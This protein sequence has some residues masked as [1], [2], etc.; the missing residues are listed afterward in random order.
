MNL[1]RIIA[2]V[3]AVMG[4][5]TLSCATSAGLPSSAPLPETNQNN[6]DTS[7]AS[8]DTRISKVPASSPE[9][10]RSLGCYELT[11]GKWAPELP[12]GED[13]GYLEPATVIE[14]T[15]ALYLNPGVLDSWRSVRLVEGSKPEYYTSA[16]W[17]ALKDDYV[18]VTFTN[19]FSGIGISVK[20]DKNEMHGRAG[21]FWDFPRE[22]QS[23]PATL[24]RVPCPRLNGRGHR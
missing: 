16:Y 10:E 5:A 6:V 14:L 13:Q 12:L 9:V 18:G 19:G 23:A 8:L 15:A 11:I 1:V 2:P 17:E 21:T 7:G 24:K 3:V 22:H 20:F 4:A